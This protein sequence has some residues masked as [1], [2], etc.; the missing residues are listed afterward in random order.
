MS[1]DAFLYLKWTIFTYES[2]YTLCEC[3]YAR[4]EQE[5]EAV[6]PMFQRQHVYHGQK[7]ACLRNSTKTWT[8][9]V[10]I[11]DCLQRNRLYTCS[12]TVGDKS[13]RVC[14]IFNDITMV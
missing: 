3:Q 11:C 14:S 4:I 9:W 7:E 10:F 12:Q 6:G 13:V 1:S 8:R 5:A 2:K